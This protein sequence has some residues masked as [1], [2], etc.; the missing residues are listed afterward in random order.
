MAKQKNR[1]VKNYVFPTPSNPLTEVGAEWRGT[2]EVKK[3]LRGYITP[4]QLQR[5]RHDVQMWREA[6]VEAEQA[7]YPNRVRM[8]R[9][10]I[11]T[12]LNGHTLACVNRRKDLTLL[13]EWSFKN[14]ADQENKDLKKLFNKKWFATFLEWALESKFFGYSLISLGDIQE[15]KFPEINLI[16]RFNI[17]P[18]RLNVTSYVYSITGAQFLEKPYKDWHVWIPTPTDVG[19]SKCGYGILYNVAL[20]EIM[21]R[22]LLGQN[23]DAAELYGMPLRVGKTTKT[24]EPERNEFMSAMLNMGS[25]GAILLDTLD[26]LE[27]VESKGMGQGY[28]IYPDLEKRL[29]NKISKIILGHADA[30]D[31][32][33]GKLGATQGE[34]SPAHMALRDKQASDGAFLED[35]VNDILIPKMIK[36][37]FNIDPL[38]KFTFDNNQELVEKRER[39][40]KNNLVT[41]QV[42]YQMKQAGLQFD[43][44]QFEEITG[45]KTTVAPTPAPVKPVFN[46]RIKNKLEELYK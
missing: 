5:I 2:S 11:D 13:R 43:P 42:A 24:E 4:V 6:I 41:A 16:R 8:Q 25:A 29:E 26:E 44:K 40:D 3:N 31:S 19:I 39:E 22:N 38:F 10:F 14:D 32:I 33:A 46:S 17:S 27:L 21:C 35:V 23:A 20:Y 36:L 34:D 7:W 15:D 37:G 9:M 18:D 12:I 1:R 30:M 45:I 28:K